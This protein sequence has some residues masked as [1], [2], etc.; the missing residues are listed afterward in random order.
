MKPSASAR[1]EASGQLLAE[2]VEDIMARYPMHKL[3]YFGQED[4]GKLRAAL[5]AYRPEIHWVQ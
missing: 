5:Q 1:T 3:T 2:S 4:L